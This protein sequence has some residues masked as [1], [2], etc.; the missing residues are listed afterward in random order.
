MDLGQRRCKPRMR[1]HLL[2]AVFTM[3]DL[4]MILFS[5]PAAQIRIFSIVMMALH[6]D[7]FNSGI[8]MNDVHLR[9]YRSEFFQPNGFKRDSG[10]KIDGRL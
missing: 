8:G 10:G 5:L 4:I 2:F 7:L 9:V 3:K 1:I 6:G